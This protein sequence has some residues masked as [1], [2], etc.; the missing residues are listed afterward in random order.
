MEV[1]SGCQWG[2][3]RRP[4]R[5]LCNWCC[6]PSRLSRRSAAFIRTIAGRFSSPTVICSRHRKHTFMWMHAH[7][8][9][10]KQTVS[11]HRWV[12][13][14]AQECNY[15]G[16]RRAAYMENTFGAI[17]WVG[18]LCCRSSKVAQRRFICSVWCI[19]EGASVTASAQTHS[20]CL[21]YHVTA[22]KAALETLHSRQ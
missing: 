9:C 21:Q 15:R 5:V 20:N 19:R 3:G 2:C 17:R 6:L 10:I 8:R 4:L 11:N 22:V 16:T 18:L 13:V 14:Q 1:Q 12:G 7:T